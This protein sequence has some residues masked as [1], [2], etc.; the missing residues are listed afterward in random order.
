MVF[1]VSNIH[2]VLLQGVT[3][4]CKAAAGVQVYH[5]T[6]DSTEQ[7]VGRDRKDIAAKS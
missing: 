2:V 1:A 4:W 3:D 7:T 6:M 5:V